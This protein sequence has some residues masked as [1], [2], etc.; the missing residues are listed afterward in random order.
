MID[1]FFEHAPGRVQGVR[2]GLDGGDLELAERSAHSLKS[3][4]ANL[5]AEALR[6][7]SGQIEELLESGAEPDARHL[8]P[9]LEA[10]FE[11]TIEA[12]EILRRP[13]ES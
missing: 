10:R 4:A 3:S 2:S 11:E 6:N 9:E 13:Q 1:L 12:L 7:L 8:L 5:G